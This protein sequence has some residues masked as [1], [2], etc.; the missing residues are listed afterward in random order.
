MTYTD[1]FSKSKISRFFDITFQLPSLFLI[2]NLFYYTCINTNT[3]TNALKQLSKNSVRL[4]QPN[5]SRTQTLW[6]KKTRLFLLLLS[7]STIACSLKYIHSFIHFTLSVIT[8]RLHSPGP[9]PDFFM[10]AS[11][12]NK[13]NSTTR[14]GIIRSI[15]G[16]PLLFDFLRISQIKL[17]PLE[18]LIIVS[19]WF[20]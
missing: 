9:T 17:L 19:C 2:L 18:A 6:L 15:K 20:G 16:H 5:F 12:P 13:F 4:P 7:Y 10:V 1:S 3:R 11:A 8:M 14:P